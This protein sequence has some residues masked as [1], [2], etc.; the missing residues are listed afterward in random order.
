LAK[1]LPQEYDRSLADKKAGRALQ[2]TP[3]TIW[4]KRLGGQKV[5]IVGGDDMDPNETLLDRKYVE[6]IKLH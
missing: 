1:A 4:S 2:D 5:L 6:A 3:E